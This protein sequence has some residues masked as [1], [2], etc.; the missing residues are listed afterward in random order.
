LR[1]VGPH[2]GKP[3]DDG[4]ERRLLGGGGKRKTL[5]GLA[6]FEKRVEEERKM[7]RSGEIPDDDFDPE[8]SFGRVVR[9]V[10]SFFFLVT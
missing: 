9:F 8:Q 7:V 2:H 1:D 3:D 10:L 6:K 4:D 5:R